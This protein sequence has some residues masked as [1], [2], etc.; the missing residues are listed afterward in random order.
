[1]TAAFKLNVC[2]QF[3]RRTYFRPATQDW[4]VA[5]LKSL[6]T[7]AYQAAT[8]EVTITGT[9]SELGSFNGQITF[10]KMILLGALEQLLLEVDPDNT[11]APPPA[12]YLPDFSSRRVMT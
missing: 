4:D 2:L 10:E 1:M 6:A 12:G 8:Q 5:S 11:P 7:D 9:S 3:L